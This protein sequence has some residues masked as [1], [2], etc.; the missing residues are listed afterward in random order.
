MISEARR[1]ITLP[2]NPISSNTVASPFSS[3]SWYDA[4]NI[5]SLFKIN[6]SAKQKIGQVDFSKGFLT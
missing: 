5:F 6:V 3:C 2:I 4:N 1:I